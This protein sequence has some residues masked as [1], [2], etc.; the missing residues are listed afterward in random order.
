MADLA[1]LSERR[2]RL[3]GER[4]PVREF[5]VFL[6]AGA[7]YAVELTR[8]REILSLPPIVEVPRAP[9]AVVGVCSVRGLLVTVFDLRRALGLEPPSLGRRARI[10]LSA[11]KSGEVIGFMVDE[12]SKVVRLSEVEI[13]PAAVALGPAAAP[14]VLGVGRPEKN[15]FIVLLDL[16]AIVTE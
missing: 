2:L 14:H 10:L 5:L 4:G 3:A 15:A 6:L 13:E 7:P 11:S 1:K 8:V 9:A 16:D 12:V